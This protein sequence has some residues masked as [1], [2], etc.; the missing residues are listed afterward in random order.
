M[1]DRYPEPLGRNVPSSYWPPNSPGRSCSWNERAANLLNRQL[2]G[3][4][5]NVIDAGYGPFHFDGTKLRIDETRWPLTN[6][7]IGSYRPPTARESFQCADWDVTKHA[8]IN[9]GFDEVVLDVA[10]KRPP[11]ISVPLAE[12]DPD[13]GQRLSDGFIGRRW[14]NS[15]MN[16]ALVP[17]FKRWKPSQLS[18]LGCVRNSCG[19]ASTFMT[20]RPVQAT[21]LTPESFGRLKRPACPRISSNKIPV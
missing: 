8:F 4:S 12:F 11:Q 10:S 16:Q 6:R 21:L 15:T 2:L 1:S 20:M 14:P 13:D 3:L 5:Q 18:P 19:W 17:K 7:S 9:A